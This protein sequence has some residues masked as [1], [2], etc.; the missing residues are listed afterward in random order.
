MTWTAPRTW[1]TTE[2]ITSSQMN[3]HVRDNLLET[4]PAKVTT[5]GDSV[6]STGAN[7]IVRL[8]VGTN[9]Q[10]LIAD[11]GSAPGVKW[12]A[13]VVASESGGS[14]TFG[15]GTGAH[16]MI[17]DGIKD[18]ERRFE[19]H[20]GGILR[21]N[22][23]ADSG[24]ESGSDVGTNFSIE[25]FDDLGVILRGEPSFFINRV[26]GLVGINESL[27]TNMTLGLTINQD[28]ND[29]EIVALKSSDVAH[30]IT[31]ATE[32]NTYF[33]ILKKDS[34]NGGV[35]MDGYNEGTIGMFLVG[36][37]TTE[38][39][40]APGN[41][42]IANVMVVG[43]KKS[44]TSVGL[45]GANAHLFAIRNFGTTRWLV[46][47]EG[48]TYRDGTSNTFD[49]WDDAQLARAFEI[50]M[51]PAKVIRSKFDEFLQYSRDD[52]VRAGILT[53][54]GSFYNESQLL[55]LVTGGL[56][57]VSTRMRETTEALQGRL[58]Q[59][60]DRIEILEQ[61]LIAND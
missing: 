43:Q 27:N 3:T 38:E 19:I 29:D 1:V 53:G 8:G 14:I 28:V 49:E 6:W 60:L 40:A 25:A 31:T 7:A 35:R 51:S 23:M 61:R 57:Q 12:T 9:G 10:V 50:E 5:K 11:S 24:T 4:A 39:T 34:A 45:Q 13:D 21:W 48:D 26:T 32:T 54:A 56:W 18:T 33:T 44:G 2:L 30:G 20:S 41:S 37:A 15:D 58:N 36:N 42:S 17:L 52:L 59:A 46:D 16:K 55:R 47:A 22:I